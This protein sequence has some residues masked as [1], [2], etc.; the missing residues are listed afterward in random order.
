MTKLGRF[1]LLEKIA[2]GGMAAVFRARY[3]G[4]KGFS[5]IVAVKRILPERACDQRFVHMFLDEARAATLLQHQN[6]VQ[7]LELGKEGDEFFI[8]MEYVEG[9]DLKQLLGM[10]RKKHELLPLSYVLYILMQILQGLDC[11]HRAKDTCGNPLHMVHRDISPSNILVSWNGEVKITDFGIAKWLHRSQETTAVGVKG[12]YSYMSPEQ[13]RGERLDHTSDLFSVGAVLFEMLTSQ[14]LFD[15]ASDL[16]IIERVKNVAMPCECFA[17][18]PPEI[19]STLSKALAPKKEMRFQTATD[20]LQEVKNVMQEKGMLVTTGDFGS[21][22]CSRAVLLSRR[23]G[24]TLSSPSSSQHETRCSQRASSHHLKVAYRA[25]GLAC[26]LLLYVP[27][28][29]HGFHLQRPLVVSQEH[30]W[31]DVHARPWGY[32][33]I[34]EVIHKRETPLRGLKILPGTYAVEVEHPPSKRR[35]SQKI[36]LLPD[37]KVHC[38]ASFQGKPS[39]SCRK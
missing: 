18:L 34:P 38:V 37:E 3:V 21:Y 16:E 13:V 32:V 25:M 30:A 35:V 29:D 31:L 22:L 26:S 14:K 28:I 7:V 17:S 20:F 39:I 2:E 11:A 15:G 5:K 19:S 27:M 6:I 10:L 9:T 24:V 33:T 23:V 1:T 12:K 36:F 4:E 8:A